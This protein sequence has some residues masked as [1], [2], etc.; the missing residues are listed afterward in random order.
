MVQTKFDVVD[1]L[2]SNIKD[3]VAV[4]V[5]VQEYH[6]ALDFLEVTSRK[7]DQ[8]RIVKESKQRYLGKLELV[9]EILAG[10]S[11]NKG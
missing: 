6:D 3:L 11:D 8:T 7:F 10:N 5:A 2:K 1:S 9:K 4:I